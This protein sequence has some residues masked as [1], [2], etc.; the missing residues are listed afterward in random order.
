MFRIYSPKVTP[1]RV[2]VVPDVRVVQDEPL[3]DVIIVPLAPTATK[4]LLPKATPLSSVETPELAALQDAP[5]G[6]EQGAEEADGHR[7][8]DAALDGGRRGVAAVAQQAQ[9][10]QHAEAAGIPAEEAGCNLCGQVLQRLQ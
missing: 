4:V 1:L 3:L 9:G 8:A 6:G 2:F 10:A 7:R 5:P